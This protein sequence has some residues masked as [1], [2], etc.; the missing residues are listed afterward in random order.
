MA[1]ARCVDVALLLLSVVE[2]PMM[3]DVMWWPISIA[4]RGDQ[5]HIYS[6]GH[7]M[8][9][10]TSES[11]PARCKFAFA[12]VHYSCA[13][14]LI[15]A[16]RHPIDPLSCLWRWVICLVAISGHPLGEGKRECEVL[17]MV[18]LALRWPNIDIAVPI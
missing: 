15:Y 10:K 6:G 13:S 4:R 14:I 16:K 1:A 9:N 17:A 7:M 11:V 18:V 3:I 5:R 12:Q 2:D 8:Q